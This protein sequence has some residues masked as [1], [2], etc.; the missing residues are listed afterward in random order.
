[1]EHF[2]PFDVA[3]VILD[4]DEE[5]LKKIIKEGNI[6]IFIEDGE[7][8]LCNYDLERY[9]LEIFGKIGRERQKEMEEY[10][11]IKEPLYVGNKKVR[12]IKC[13]TL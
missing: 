5:T 13:K 1:M 4:V 10:G 12:R 7:P 3:M 2:I 6:R 11:E 9:V 8:K